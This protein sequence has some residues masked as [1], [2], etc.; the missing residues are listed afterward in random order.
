[1]SLWHRKPFIAVRVLGR[2]GQYPAFELRSPAHL[3]VAN[4]TI[5]WTAVF[6]PPVPDAWELPESPILVPEE[7]R[8]LS[9]IALCEANPWDRGMPVITL[10]GNTNV[11]PER[12]GDN[13]MSPK[14]IRQLEQ[15]A[16]SIGTGPRSLR[17][18]R[19]P[20]GE[21]DGGYVVAS[22]VGRLEDRFQSASVSKKWVVILRGQLRRAVL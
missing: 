20:D 2:D 7:V 13:L 3:Y 14:A 5:V 4:Q 22:T 12:I 6:Q 16:R 8:L 18:S 10:W 1:V 9:S 21:D 17:Y 11:E 15:I 19:S